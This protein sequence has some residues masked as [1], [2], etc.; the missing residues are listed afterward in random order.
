MALLESEA[1]NPDATC[2]VEKTASDVPPPMI[3]VLLGSIHVCW[4]GIV[5][6]GSRIVEGTLTVVL[7]LVPRNGLMAQVPGE[8]TPRVSI[9]APPAGYVEAGVVVD[10]K[11]PLIVEQ[12]SPLKKTEASM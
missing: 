6:A 12:I 3:R 1:V 9:T 11:M 10:F 4:I 5:T 2:K 7:M 8:R